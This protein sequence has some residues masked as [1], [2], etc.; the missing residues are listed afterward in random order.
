MR[1]ILAIV[2]DA[3]EPSLIEQWMDD[4]SLPNLKRLREQGMHGRLDSV[5]GGLEEAVPYCFYTGQNPASHGAHSY[6][7]FQKE[8]MKFRS[9]GPDWLPMRP[10]WRRFREGGPRAIVLDV[11]NCYPPEP[12]NGLEISGWATHWYS[13]APFQTYP[14]DLANWI[15]QR[16]GSSILPD[17]MY[18][19]VS[20]QDFIKTRDLMLE[21]SGK[22]GGLCIELMRRES[23]DLFLAF[24]F[25]VHHS[26][27]R[28]WSPINIKEPL[29][30]SEHAEL[31]DALRQVYIA[32]DRAVGEIVQAAGEDVIVMVSSLHGM[33]I[34][35]SRT[36][37]FPEMLRRVLREKRDNNFTPLSLIKR[38]RNLVP[39][40][41]RHQIK[42]R[43][44]YRVRRW[45]TRFWRVSG[46]NWKKTKAFDLFSDTQGWVRIN[47]K[48]RESQGIVE[49]HEYEALCQRI[50]EGLKS[51]V[52][53]DTGQ[54]VVKK[55]VAPHQVF[56]GE[57]IDDLPDLIVNWADSPA[58]M[59]RA[60]VSPQYGTIPW[61]TPGHNPEGRSGNHIA[62]GMLIASGGDI[63]SGKIDDAN[64]L[65][66]APT[67]LTLLGQPVP[68]EM[69]G[70]VLP[71]LR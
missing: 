51:F 41:L 63:K 30:E 18:G 57:K 25:T 71:I 65:D 9:P 24:L 16:Y 8:T 27:H 47:L 14:P 70:K 64:I 4:G 10:F 49:P 56:E 40:E 43:L 53:V 3:A 69:E 39:V 48:G 11:S 22:F 5:G 23:W 68:P 55:I 62:Q 17:E 58:A 21:I 33:G 52:D 45:L 1:R 2:L 13:L 50:S 12:F 34:N 6:V 38:V 46:H 19:L 42:S 15:H 37:I 44:P 66:L 31:G 54:P 26:G 28:L 59:H 29:T 67:I 7:M 36:W 32:A 61:P 20:K 35:K 60:M